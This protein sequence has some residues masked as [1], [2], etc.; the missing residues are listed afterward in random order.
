MKLFVIGLL[1]WMIGFAM[2]RTVQPSNYWPAA[3][4]GGLYGASCFYLARKS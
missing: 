2:G 1:M 3:I 4:L